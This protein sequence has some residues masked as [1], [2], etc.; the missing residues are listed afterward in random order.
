MRTHLLEQPSR[1]YTLLG[2]T[3]TAFYL[4]GGMLVGFGLGFLVHGGLPGHLREGLRIALG[5]AAAL[6]GVLAGGALWG[7]RLG[8]LGGLGRPQRTASFGGLGFGLAIVLAV[9]LLSVIEVQVL[10]SGRGPSLA[11]HVLYTLLFVPA[12]ALVAAGGALALCLA[13]GCRAHE[14]AGLFSRA[15]LAAGAAFL[16]VNL[17]MDALG[18]RVGAP[19]AVERAT[20]LTVT[21]VGAFGAA[22]AG[23]AVV[24]RW[25]TGRARE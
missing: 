8:R 10:E 4:V 17:A 16:T 3:Y 11:V 22:L 9:V 20:M 18:W 19:G 7:S 5:S 23:G 25:V 2:A 14:A 1:R 15:G 13:A 6:T 12:A 24:G 21:L